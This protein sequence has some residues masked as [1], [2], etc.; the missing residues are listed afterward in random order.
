MQST[1]Q[2]IRKEADRQGYSVKRLADESGVPYASV[3]R[4]LKGDPKRP[5]YDTIDRLKKTLAKG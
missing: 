1:I 4:I 2:H 3:Y 5:A